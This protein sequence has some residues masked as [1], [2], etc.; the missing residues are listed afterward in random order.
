VQGQSGVGILSEGNGKDAVVTIDWN[1]RRADRA[2]KVWGKTN[3]LDGAWHWP[4]NEATQFFKVE[5]LM[6]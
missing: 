3:L 4:T 2:Y 1:S 6:K 5:A